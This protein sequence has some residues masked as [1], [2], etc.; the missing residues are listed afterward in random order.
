MNDKICPICKYFGRITWGNHAD[1]IY[2]E[3][4]AVRLNLCYYHSVDLFKTGQTNFLTKYHEV[5]RDY[6][7]LGSAPSF[8][9][10]RHTIFNF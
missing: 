8:A 3:R 9:G 10:P 6:D 1:H 7:L 4:Q 5:F 2:Q